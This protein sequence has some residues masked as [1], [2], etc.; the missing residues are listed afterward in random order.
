MGDCAPGVF[1]SNIDGNAFVVC[2]DVQF[3]TVILTG[4]SGGSGANVCGQTVGASTC[5]LCN[6]TGGNGGLSTAIEFTIN[7]LSAGDELALVP[8][9]L[10]A[11]SDEVIACT[12]GVEGWND[13]DCGPAS[14][15]ENG[16]TTH[17]LLN[18]EVIAEI[19]GGSG[20]TGACI[21][22]QGDGCFNGNPGQNGGVT[23]IAPWIFYAEETQLVGAQGGQM[24]LYY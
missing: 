6:A 2:P 17:L 19:S 14:D 9:I 3:V 23:L 22:C 8:G 5:N 16:G 1:D 4:A 20:G 24:V 11:N 18:G 13:W 15:G 10:G 7:N 21:G 12:P